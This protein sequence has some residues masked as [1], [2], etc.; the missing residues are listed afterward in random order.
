MALPI[1]WRLSSLLPKRILPSLCIFLSLQASQVL[2][3]QNGIITPKLSLQ[4]EETYIPGAE[5]YV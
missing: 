5:N 3:L 4:L 1:I 2:I